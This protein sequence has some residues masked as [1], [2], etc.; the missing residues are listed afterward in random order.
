MVQSA[1]GPQLLGI[2]IAV[3]VSLGGSGCA[4]RS[5]PLATAAAAK[6]AG[7]TAHADAA[8]HADAAA[9]GDP[10]AR[11]SPDIPAAAHDV[12]ATEPAADGTAD[13]TTVDYSNPAVLDA[14]LLF[15]GTTTADD[16]HRARIALARA[17]LVAL[18]HAK[19][20]R[21]EREDLET[22]LQRELEAAKRRARETNQSRSVR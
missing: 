21:D 10:T 12:N 16:R 15:S 20:M 11:A 8:V 2:A 22:Q 5:P 9:R 18:S 7:S 1:W 17:A 3:L 14:A 6:G 4:H 13:A 19:E